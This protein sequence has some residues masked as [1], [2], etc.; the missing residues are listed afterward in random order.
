MRRISKAWSVPQ[1]LARCL[2]KQ[3]DTPIWIRLDGAP[4]MGHR[5]GQW[6]GSVEA[7]TMTG[8]LLRRMT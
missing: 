1:D 4:S 2:N 7:S 8:A 6:S 5:T 3:V